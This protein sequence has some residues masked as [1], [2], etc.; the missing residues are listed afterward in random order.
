MTE[1]C[2]AASTGSTPRQRSDNRTALSCWP[3]ESRTGFGHRPHRIRAATIFDVL[4][5]TNR[6]VSLMFENSESGHDKS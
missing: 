2:I 3:R 4:T 5:G 6:N 1:R